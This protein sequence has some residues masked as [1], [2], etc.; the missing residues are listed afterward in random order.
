MLAV[1]RQ[2][3]AIYVDKVSQQWVVRD[4][5]GNFWILP[6]TDNPWSDRQ[7]FTPNDEAELESVPGHYRYMLCLPP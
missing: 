7:S 4:A 3:V 2:V 1:R 6:S 5:E